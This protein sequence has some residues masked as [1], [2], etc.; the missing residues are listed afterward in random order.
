M[1]IKPISWGISNINLQMVGKTGQ[2][3]QT[4]RGGPAARTERGQVCVCVHGGQEEPTICGAVERRGVAS[5]TAFGGNQ[6]RG[7]G[8]GSRRAR[9]KTGEWD[10]LAGA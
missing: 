8:K 6:H 7:E 4:H 3:E 2:L 10:N 9:V 1:A 5:L